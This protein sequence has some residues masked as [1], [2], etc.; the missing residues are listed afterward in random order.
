VQNTLSPPTDITQPPSF[1][2]DF[3][4][5]YMRPR[6]SIHDGLHVIDASVASQETNGVRQ[7]QQHAIQPS[8]HL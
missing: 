3:A 5:D 8:W 1:G 7:K 6:I 2:Y 4:D